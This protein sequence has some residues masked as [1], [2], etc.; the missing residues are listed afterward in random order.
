MG[1][2][3]LLDLFTCPV[4]GATLRAHD[5]DAARV[6]CRNGHRFSFGRGYLDLSDGSPGHGTT[7]RTFESFGFEWNTFDEVRDE[8][9]QFA[10]AYFRDL[11][12]ASL[13]GKTGVDAGCGKGRYTRFL[14]PY[15]DALVALDGSS[16]VEAAVRNLEPFGNVLVVK[17]DL[18]TVPMVDACADLVVSL[19]V[20]HHLDDPRAGFLQLTRLLAPDGRILVYLYSRPDT[21]GVRAAA[22]AAAAVIRKLTVRVPLRL[23]R[24]LAV[25]IAAILWAGVVVPGSVGARRQVEALER[26]PMAAYRAK[27]FRS[28]VLDT[29][30][31]LSAPVEH[32]Y[33][34]EELAPWFDEAGLD[35][36][37]V[38]EEAGWFV[39]AR[40]PSGAG[41]Q[42][43]MTR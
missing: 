7:A 14:A 8:D 40:R 36:E 12:M 24:V 2:D 42:G 37:A 11:D 23:L 10:R 33:V 15:L 20:L 39:L 34:W 21:F 1:A 38:R 18:R 28:L 26:L 27:P 3:R 17:A 4:C 35:L 41:A 22:L 16:A 29:F 13:A 32:R 19:G 6:G 43:A 25:P 5:G 31:R 9:V 30:D